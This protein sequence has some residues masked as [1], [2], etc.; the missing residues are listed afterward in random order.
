MHPPSQLQNVKN[1][2]STLFEELNGSTPNLAARVLSMPPVERSQFM[3]QLMMTEP[4]K[5][6]RLH[7]LLTPIILT[8][9][10]NIAR[11]AVRCGEEEE[12][13]TEN[14]LSIPQKEAPD[15]LHQDGEPNW[16]VDNN[17]LQGNLQFGGEAAA[18]VD[19]QPMSL[20]SS[21]I[22]ES[23][24]FGSNIV[25]SPL[26]T[27]EFTPASGSMPL[28][29]GV[30]DSVEE[31][32]KDEEDD[33]IYSRPLKR[34]CLVEKRLQNMW[35]KVARVDKEDAVKV[36]GRSLQF[37]AD[38]N[39]TAHLT[40]HLL[41][42]HSCYEAPKPPHQPTETEKAEIA[43]RKERR[44]NEQHETGR[45]FTATRR[46]TTDLDSCCLPIHDA[47]DVQLPH[48]P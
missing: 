6:R 41:A 17:T 44:K 16:S 37:G 31:P 48:R 47:M 29:P 13:A 18:M 8:P 23:G 36:T 42:Y 3:K 5:A 39:T 40:S 46:T 32:S 12:I 2:T 43:I 9:M 25:P 1:E 24:A 28:Q 15:R 20:K 21:Q 4:V 19:L 27:G 22:Q 35:N 45:L 14:N 7:S 34:L 33:D 38:T 11:A 26:K 10:Q 30:S